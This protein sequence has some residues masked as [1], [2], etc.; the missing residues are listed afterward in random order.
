[1][2]KLEGQGLHEGPRPGKPKKAGVAVLG[3]GVRAEGVSAGALALPLF[4]Q[5]AHGEGC[6]CSHCLHFLCVG[7]WHPGYPGVWTG[8]QVLHAA[9]VFT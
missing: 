8:G 9:P 7:P 2:E 4:S 1:M 3:S 6:Q 5:D